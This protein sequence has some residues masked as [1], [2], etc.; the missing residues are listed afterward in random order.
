MDVIPVTIFPRSQSKG[1]NTSQ[2]ASGRVFASQARAHDVSPELDFGVPVTIAG[3]AALSGFPRVN[4]RGSS[5]SSQ[6]APGR[7]FALRAQQQS[8]D[9]QTQFSV[10]QTIAGPAVV[11]GGFPRALSHGS[12][13]SSQA[14]PGRTFASQ[15][16]QFAVPVTIPG[17]DA[18]ANFPRS[19]SRGSDASGATARAR[20]FASQAAQQNPAANF[21]R[22]QS[23]GSHASS[24]AASV[25]VFASQARQSQQALS[26]GH[27][28]RFSSQPVPVSLP[29]S[30]TPPVL[31]PQSMSSGRQFAHLPPPSAGYAAHMHTSPYGLGLG[32][33]I[34]LVPLPMQ[35]YMQHGL[36]PMVDSEDAKWFNDILKYLWP[37]IC[38][39]VGRQLKRAMLKMALGASTVWTRNL[40]K[41]IDKFVTRIGKHE[42]QWPLTVTWLNTIIE[43]IWEMAKPVFS[44]FVLQELL[45]KIEHAFPMGLKGSK[46]DPCELGDSPPRFKKIKTERRKNLTSTGTYDA[47]HIE[48]DIEWNSAVDIG[49][50]AFLNV[51]LKNIGISGKLHIILVEIMDKPP[52]I[53]GLNMY[54]TSSP[55]VTMDW[56][57]ALDILDMDGFE[58]LIKGKIQ[59]AIDK[60]LVLPRRIGVQMSPD[61]DVFR[62]KAPR[63][64]GILKITVLRANGL[65]AADFH[66][67]SLLPEQGLVTPY[68]VM[69]VGADERR[70]KVSHKVDQEDKSRGSHAAEWDETFYWLVHEPSDQ[71]IDIVIKHQDLY[72]GDGILRHIGKLNIW[73]LLN[74]GEDTDLMKEP[75]NFR[76]KIETEDCR[77]VENARIHQ[78]FQGADNNDWLSVRQTSGD[79]D[80]DTSF[81]HKAT[82]EVTHVAKRVMNAAFKATTSVLHDV[83]QLGARASD[84]LKHMQ[85]LNSTKDYLTG[86]LELVVTWRPLEFNVPFAKMIRPSAPDWSCAERH[87]TTML[88]VGIYGAWDL[89]RSFQRSATTKFFAKVEVSPTFCLW[90]GV[91]VKEGQVQRT[92]G[93]LGPTNDQIGLNTIK[94][95]DHA[96][97]KKALD[98][99]I[100]TLVKQ[101][102]PLF[103]IARVLGVNVKRVEQTLQAGAIEDAIEEVAIPWEQGFFFVLNDPRAATVRIEC[104]SE[105]GGVA[106]PL[107]YYNF[108]VAD[109]LGAPNLTT[110]VLGEPLEG[111]GSESGAQ[112]S[113]RMQLRTF[114]MGK[115][116]PRP[117]PFE[118]REMPKQVIE[119]ADKHGRK[120]V[121]VNGQWQQDEPS[122]D[123]EEEVA[124]EKSL[125]E[126]A[127]DALHKMQAAMQAAEEKVLDV[128]H[129]VEEKVADA[130]HNAAEKLHD[131]EEAVAE[132][133]HDVV[134]KIH[135]VEHAVAEKIHDVEDA[136][137]DG[138]SHAA[139]AVADAVHNVEDKIEHMFHHEELPALPVKVVSA[140]KLTDVDGGG[141][142]SGVSDPYCICHVVGKS[143]TT[144]QTKVVWNC[145]DPVWDHLGQLHGYIPGDSVVFEVWDHDVFPKR[146]TMIGSVTVA[147]EEFW[148][149][150]L[151]KE[152]QLADADGKDVGTLHI[153]IELTEDDIQALEGAAR[154]DAAPT[155]SSGKKQV[156]GPTEKDKKRTAVPVTVVSAAGLA[157]VDGG[158]LSGVSDP[159]CIC[160]VLGK[161]KTTFQTSVVWNSLDPVWNCA[162]QLHGFEPGDVISFEV[163]DKEVFPKNDK[164]IGSVALKTEDFWPHGL[165]GTNLQLA[166]DA[167]KSVGTLR[168]VIDLTDDIVEALGGASAAATLPLSAISS[169]QK[170]PTSGGSL[171][172][173]PG[174]SPISVHTAAPETAEGGAAV[175]PVKHRLQVVF[176]RAN[177]LKNMDGF[178]AGVSDP[179]CICEVAGGEPESSK[180]QSPVVWN[181]LHPV[182]NHTD[183]MADY[184]QGHG[185]KFTVWDKDTWP[186]S[187]DLLG[188]VVLPAAAFETS[189][190][191]GQLTLS[192]DKGEDAG[193]LFV[194]VSALEEHGE[195]HPPLTAVAASCNGSTPSQSPALQS[196]PPRLPGSPEQKGST[197]A[198]IARSGALTAGEVAAEGTGIRP[199][200]S[201]D[202]VSPPG[203]LLPA[204]EQ[205]RDGATREA[206]ISSMDIDDALFCM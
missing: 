192:D 154:G 81:M 134:D 120:K 133:F 174:A 141:F 11:S 116:F 177:D 7:V 115:K 77:E 204:E 166:D 148:P 178:L 60:A 76:R 90:R 139:H 196:R 72:R 46:I 79:P 6:A 124:K 9:S 197:D 18:M 144:F 51:G 147:A 114:N 135:D 176:Q 162:G 173:S 62:V 40:F 101:N 52:F 98:R 132:K 100:V 73:K 99:K 30:F 198:N 65:R 16:Q 160:H 122:S 50:Q 131:A 102:V 22:S 54:F 179:Y 180:I 34:P 1:S 70:T 205:L 125:A 48:V 195:A 42:L 84:E 202:D 45:P 14:G 27:P 69:K 13:T 53:G 61:I 172:H 151:R 152:L 119:Y 184:L 199:G 136:V 181:D 78:R 36:L 194:S 74:I 33:P 107:G 158:W 206:A 31:G 164:T 8:L 39:L 129:T 187:D 15:A 71:E 19:H 193:R 24:Q 128:V 191:R 21:P 64:R 161:K 41:D 88:F 23:H 108:K 96:N 168:V 190:F 17:P 185:L 109:L 170:P 55:D 137:V 149:H 26:S 80:E 66:L 112:I 89:H 105:D 57:G 186:K 37:H 143:K 92:D 5:T 138:V 58:H 183:E 130:V 35:Q 56:T 121:M 145:L 44:Q 142:L 140:A 165:P 85:G 201:P 157:N 156:A 38:V 2:P 97:S 171:P 86:E 91:E 83:E 43:D 167:G 153:A 93:K 29:G 82:G 117:T 104:S 203:Q 10:P 4:S 68:V 188:Y 47:L 150:G 118:G 12:N 189:G 200:S 95:K 20:V 75:H 111:D 3:P 123:S 94:G 159:Y 28:L 155:T 67:T 182:W 63:P 110:E 59:E 87:F 146:D 163:W 175:A 113:L 169:P 25:R 103:L 32:A 126:R 127:K 106:V 49:L